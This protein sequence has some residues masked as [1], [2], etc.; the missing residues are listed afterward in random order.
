MQS[1]AGPLTTPVSL[2][3][4][5][6]NEIIEL[7]KK[8]FSPAHQSLFRD[9]Y[10]TNKIN[11]LVRTSLLV[12]QSSTICQHWN[13]GKFRYDIL[14]KHLICRHLKNKLQWAPLNY[15]KFDTFNTPKKRA[16]L[17]KLTVNILS[18]QSYYGGRVFSPSRSTATGR[19]QC[20]KP[21]GLN[22]AKGP[23]LFLHLFS[24]CMH[25]C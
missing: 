14:W 21:T 19:A 1:I 10:F 4:R 22:S 9:L 18:S 5:S 8:H 6:F 16:H 11:S 12:L 20:R 25:A 3:T 15:T 2:K 17:M 23:P 24:Q 7:L 13:L